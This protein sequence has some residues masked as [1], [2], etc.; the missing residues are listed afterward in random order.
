L[1]TVV[2]NNGPKSQERLEFRRLNYA[3]SAWV[4]QTILAAPAAVAA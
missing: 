4:R 1:R 3:D 2:T